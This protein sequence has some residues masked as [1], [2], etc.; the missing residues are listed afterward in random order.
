MSIKEVRLESELIIFS[1]TLKP[2]FEMSTKSKPKPKKQPPDPTAKCPVL[3]RT[4]RVIQFGIGNFIQDPWRS[5][6][7]DAV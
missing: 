2:F 4:D 6:M 1:L 3:V 5:R 7:V